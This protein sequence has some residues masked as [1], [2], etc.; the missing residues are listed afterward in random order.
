MSVEEFCDYRRWAVGHRIVIMGVTAPTVY[1][2]LFILK[3]DF[4]F[5]NKITSG[6]L[7]GLTFTLIS[8]RNMK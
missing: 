3:N 1:D 2:L 6:T 5:E 7:S 4:I 8:D